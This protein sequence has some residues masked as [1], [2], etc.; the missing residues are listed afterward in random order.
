MNTVQKE[1]IF[2]AL[3]AKNAVPI[4]SR[5]EGPGHD[6]VGY[7]YVPVHDSHKVKSDSPPSI[8]VVLV[9]CVT[10]GHITQHVV[11]SLGVEL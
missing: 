11:S 9:V 5:C 6:I 3:R 10:C 8:P 2:R 1:L 4:C 7:S